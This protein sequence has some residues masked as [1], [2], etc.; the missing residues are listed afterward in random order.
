[1]LSQPR[2]QRPARVELSSPEASVPGEDSDR[3][4]GLCGHSVVKCE[5]DTVL[6]CNTGSFTFLLERL[7]CEGGVSMLGFN[8]YGL[9]LMTC[10]GSRASWS[11]RG[12]QAMEIK[13]AQMSERC[14]FSKIQY[15]IIS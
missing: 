11:S 12:E 9:L 1:M 10:K 14:E 7:Y 4:H 6:P 5:A 13:I 8:Y 15:K 2:Q 3:G